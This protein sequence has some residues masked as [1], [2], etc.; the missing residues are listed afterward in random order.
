MPVWLCVSN[1]R[2]RSSPTASRRGASQRRQVS[3]TT[4]R[5]RPGDVYPHL[6]APFASAEGGA[7][8]SPMTSHA[9]FSGS[10]SDRHPD[11]TLPGAIS[12]GIR[13]MKR[14]PTPRDSPSH[15][16]PVHSGLITH[17]EHICNECLGFARRDL[18]HDAGI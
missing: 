4:V 13:P 6:A 11:P 7:V 15:V 18:D 5:P 16:P 2:R 17:P 3:S 1:C 14:A 10:I 8:A 9:N 12:R